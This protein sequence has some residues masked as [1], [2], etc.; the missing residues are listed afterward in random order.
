MVRS[1]TSSKT[2]YFTLKKAVRKAKGNYTVTAARQLRSGALSVRAAM[3]ERGIARTTARRLK[4]AKLSAAEKRALLVRGIDQAVTKLLQQK[5][6]YKNTKQ[7]Q[8]KRLVSA[9]AIRDKMTS[10]PSA[11]GL[12]SDFKV[13]CK[14]QIE[15][16]LRQLNLDRPARKRISE[17]LF[18]TG[19]TEQQW[20][21]MIQST[22]YS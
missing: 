1:S 17:K 10:T 22:R 6:S 2:A 4:N 20:R 13:P 8:P 21:S 3:R 18:N 19:I 11:C 14:R 12:P 9:Q 16:V 5:R 7:E 15:R